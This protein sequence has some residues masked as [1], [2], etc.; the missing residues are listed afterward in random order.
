MLSSLM[1]DS[2]TRA[3]LKQKY[4]HVDKI[5]TGRNKNYNFNGGT[6]SGTDVLSSTKVGSNFAVICCFRDFHDKYSKYEAIN[7]IP[8]YHIRQLY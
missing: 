3:K 6:S 5:F 8:Y 4:N 1:V 7:G 2:C